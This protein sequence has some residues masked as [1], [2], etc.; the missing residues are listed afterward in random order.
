MIFF[1]HSIKETM[2]WTE[3][4]IAGTK[5]VYADGTSWRCAAVHWC[6]HTLTDAN[7][8]SRTMS[9]PHLNSQ[10]LRSHHAHPEYAELHSHTQ[11]HL[12]HSYIHS[13]FK[14]GVKA[15]SAIFPKCTK[16]LY[17]QKHITF[18]ENVSS[19]QAKAEVMN[20]AYH[21]DWE[22]PLLQ[23]QQAMFMIYTMCFCVMCKIWHNVSGFWK[24]S[25]PTWL[26]NMGA[27]LSALSQGVAKRLPFIVLS[28]IKQTPTNLIN[29]VT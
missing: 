5:Y 3:C 27:V 25:R 9:F 2:P 19:L 28:A 8:H 4:L 10:G 7:A 18:K 29:P 20:W 23:T 22:M 14:D 26:H 17:H 15:Q 16:L 21:R 24:V 13:L 6:V 11:G 12:K 1:D